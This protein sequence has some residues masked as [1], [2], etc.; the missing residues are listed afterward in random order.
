MPWS[1]R[2]SRG[3]GYDIIKSDTG[4]KVGHSATKAEAEA[5]VRARYSNYSR[6]WK[7]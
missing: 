5:S 2:K 3:P 1:V 6:K 7:R 4:A